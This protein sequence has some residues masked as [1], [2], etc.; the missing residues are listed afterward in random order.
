MTMLAI[1]I[2]LPFLNGVGLYTP[3]NMDNHGRCIAEPGSYAAYL[4]PTS[5]WDANY[6]C[7][8]HGECPLGAGHP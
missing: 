2:A 1:L 4:C 7:R 5:S 6:R 3:H 8:S